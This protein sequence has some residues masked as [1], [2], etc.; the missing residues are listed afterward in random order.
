M[1]PISEPTVANLV[2]TLEEITATLRQQDVK[3]ASTSTNVF[4]LIA[5][6]SKIDVCSRLSGWSRTAS[7]PAL[8]ATLGFHPRS[9]GTLRMPLHEGL[10]GMV[11]EQLIP[12]A[13]SPRAR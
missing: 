10:S 4:P 9:I 1:T 8:A 12:V 3:L 11:A 7:N 5:T 13:G 6:R 2:L